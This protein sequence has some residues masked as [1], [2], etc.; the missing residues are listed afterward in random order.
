MVKAL[1]ALP[2]LGRWS[3]ARARGRTWLCA[4]LEHF[5]PA[6]TAAIVSIAALTK[7]GGVPLV[8]QFDGLFPTKEPNGNAVRNFGSQAAAAPA[9]VSGEPVPNGHWVLPGKAATGGDPRARRPTVDPLARRA[10][11]LGGT[12]VRR[13]RPARD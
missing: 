6:A 9:T 12:A 5:A 10:G 11:C 8:P 4:G 2:R 1:R 13:T 3:A 7:R